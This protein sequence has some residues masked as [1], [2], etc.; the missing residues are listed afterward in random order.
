MWLQIIG[1]KA[2]NIDDALQHH[3]RKQTERIR[4]RTATDKICIMA[5]NIIRDAHN[6]FVKFERDTFYF[7]TF[8]TIYKQTF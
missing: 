2:V 1:D 6:I 5:C 4:H 3:K 7:K 8:F